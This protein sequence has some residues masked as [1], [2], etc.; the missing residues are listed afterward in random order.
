M[1]VDKIP[2]RKLSKDD[3]LG[4]WQKALELRNVMEEGLVSQRW[5][6]A[7]LNGIHAAI[8]ANDALLIFFHGVKSASQKHDDAVRLLT[9][10]MKTEEARQNARHLSKLIH[11]KS[12]IEYTGERLRQVESAELC[13]HAQ[14]FNPGTP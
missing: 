6:A 2:R 10:L 12:I 9:T 11:R 3:Y 14:R 7:A 5:D 13:K 4:C 1:S 8:L